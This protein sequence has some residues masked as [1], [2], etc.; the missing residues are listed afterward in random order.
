VRWQ[1]FDGYLGSLWHKRRRE[2]RSE[3]RA[4]E[5]SGMEV[6][7]VDGSRLGELLDELAPLF[8]N[9]Q[10]RYGHGGGVA[11]ARETI[12]WV[13]QHLCPLTRVVL[14]NE[15]GRTVAFHLLYE[16]DGTLYCYLT[17]QTYEP[18][19]QEA[20]A[21]FQAVYYKPIELAI[22]WGIRR[23][24]FG[25]ESYEAKLWRGCE[26]EWALGLF[27]FGDD[28]RAELSELVGLV[29][30]AQRQRFGRYARYRRLR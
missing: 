22:Q 15:A 9:L 23:I 6:V 11:E 18:S 17:G 13:R 29:D 7:V 14:I 1:S 30:A 8:A 27:D 4:F 2:V 10:R 21:Y 28:L 24:D 25:N 26:P 16:L 19:V 12:D 3:L 5:T 20:G